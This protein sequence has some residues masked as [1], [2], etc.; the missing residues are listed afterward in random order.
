MAKPEI[1][2]TITDPD[3]GDVLEEKIV[4]NDYLLIC[5]GRRYLKS[6]QQWGSTHMLA[7]AYDK[8]GTV[9]KNV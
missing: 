4:A 1:K 8:D 7:V 2:V 5:A 3:T 9:T 6:V